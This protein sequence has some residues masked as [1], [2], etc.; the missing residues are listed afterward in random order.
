MIDKFDIY[1]KL[2]DFSNSLQVY[3]EANHVD[4]VT[5]VKPFDVANVANVEA[6]D[7]IH[8]EVG[9]VVA[10]LFSQFYNLQFV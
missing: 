5:N 10:I 1:L 3:V 9:D 8:D 2:F 7:V 4:D 6:F